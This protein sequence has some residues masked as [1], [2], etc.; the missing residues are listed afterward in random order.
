MREMAKELKTMNELECVINKAI[1]GNVSLSLF[2]KLP[3]LT[4]PEIITNP[5]V[6]L[7]QKL[8]YY[9]ETYNDGLEHKYADGVKILGW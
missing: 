1:K 8:K 3:D 2:I 6:N 9:K 7:E 4:E 5:P